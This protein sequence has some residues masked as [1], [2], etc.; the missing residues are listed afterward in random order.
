MTKENIMQ[1][2]ARNSLKGK[3][4]SIE[5]GAVN[6][7][8]IIELSNGAEVVSIITKDS[9]KRLNL[10]ESKTVHAVAKAS[11]VMIAID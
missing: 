6:S 4:K 11:D 9:A 1:I 5:A 10:S 2:S 8:V 7:Q 3:I